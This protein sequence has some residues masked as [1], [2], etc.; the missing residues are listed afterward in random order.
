VEWPSGN[1][2]APKNLATVADQRWVVAAIGD[3]ELNPF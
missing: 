2:A 1:G 3:F